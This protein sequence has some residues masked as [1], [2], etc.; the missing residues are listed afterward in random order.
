MYV[1]VGIIDD[2]SF[3][4]CYMIWFNSGLVWGILVLGLYFKEKLFFFFN[5]VND[6]IVKKCFFYFI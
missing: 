2:W 1:V 4:E 6:V 3:W 5:R